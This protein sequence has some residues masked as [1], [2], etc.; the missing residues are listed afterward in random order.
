MTIPLTL[1]SFAIGLV[2]AVAIALIRTAKTPVL[3]PLARIYV[4]IFRGTPAL[5]Q[6]LSSLA[7]RASALSSTPFR[8]P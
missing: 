4:W 3:E 7:S 6:L 1:I 5:V 2:V 8:R